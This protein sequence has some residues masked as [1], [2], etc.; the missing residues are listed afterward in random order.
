M[1]GDF[2]VYLGVPSSAVFPEGG[3][4]AC[5]EIARGFCIMKPVDI[6]RLAGKVDK[7]S[8]LVDLL[9]RADMSLVEQVLAPMWKNLDTEY[10]RKFIL[11]GAGVRFICTHRT[12]PM[13]KTIEIPQGTTLAEA[14]ENFRLGFFTSGGTPLAPF[15]NGERADDSYCLQGG[16]TVEFKL[17]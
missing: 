14:K 5:A 11:G 2:D 15:V 7:R 4:A 8:L 6:V 10:V 9:Q 12:C 17:P 13:D 1:Q 16:E 3:S